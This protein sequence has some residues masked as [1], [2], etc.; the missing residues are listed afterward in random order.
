MCTRNELAFPLNVRQDPIYLMFIT[1]N[2]ILK[3][4]NCLESGGQVGFFFEF[5]SLTLSEYLYC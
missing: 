3:F 1:L 4:K 5:S 2:V